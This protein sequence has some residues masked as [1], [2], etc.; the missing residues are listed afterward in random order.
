MN[1]EKCSNVSKRLRDEA[2]DMSLY[3]QAKS[4]ALDYMEHVLDQPVFPVPELDS[5]TLLILQAD[6]VNT[7]AFDDFQTLYQKAA[8][9][10][11]WVHVDG[12]LGLWVAASEELRLC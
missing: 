6:N 2:L 3:E 7:G 5:R 10:G 4:H 12:A 9:A 11:S 1:H 8:K